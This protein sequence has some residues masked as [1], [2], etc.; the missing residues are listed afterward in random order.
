MGELGRGGFGN[1]V[2]DRGEGFVEL[3]YLVGFGSLEVE[4]WGSFYGGL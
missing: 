3:V 2:I 1:F 4:E